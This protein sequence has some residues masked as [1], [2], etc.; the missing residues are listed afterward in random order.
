MAGAIVGKSADG[1]IERMAEDA[2]NRLSLRV[3]DEI[4]A[5]IARHQERMAKM[6]GAP[7]TRTQ[8]V[9]SL[10]EMGAIAW[11]A[12]ERVGALSPAVV[13]AVGADTL[14]KGK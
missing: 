6:V 12:C 14:Q 3:S 5:T 4:M 8:A 11:A 9:S 10:V 7:F 13:I 1:R 2:E